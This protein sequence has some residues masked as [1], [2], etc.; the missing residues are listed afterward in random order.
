VS[1]EREREQLVSKLRN[2]GLEERVCAAVGRVP[3][4]AFVGAERRS[5]AYHD[6]PLPIGDGQTISAPHIIAL[7]AERL[8]LS[9]GMELL[10]IGTGCGYHAAV[11]AELV[12]PENVS[13]VELSGAL[14]HSARR[15]LEEVGY[16]EISVRVG[17]GREGWPANAPYDAVYLACACESFPSPLLEQLRE[18]GQILGPVGTGSQQLVSGKKQ[19]D[20]TLSTEQLSHVRFVEMQ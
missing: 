14:G 19:A 1:F 3:R 20:G 12:G 4:H 2:R 7:M 18:G 8:D 10:E 16:E 6:Q 5:Q 15:R 17:D 13:T 11:T 9:S